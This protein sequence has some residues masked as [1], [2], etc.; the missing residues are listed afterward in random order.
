MTALGARAR[1]K[2]CLVSGGGGTTR[3]KETYKPIDSGG[4]RREGYWG[5]TRRR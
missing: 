5:R 2:G 1:E 4:C 3:S